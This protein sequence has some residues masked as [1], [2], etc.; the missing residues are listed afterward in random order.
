LKL[1][2][3]V[4]HIA[5]VRQA[6]RG[7]FPDP[8]RA[9]L[10]CQAAG[11]DAIVAHLREDRR[12]IQ[13][14][15]VRRL[16]SALRIKLNLEMAI[17]P[18]VLKTALAVCPHTATLVPERRKERTTE[19]GLDMVRDRSRLARATDSLRRRG[20]EVSF[21]VD[22][23]AAHIDAA[24][25]CGAHAVEIHTGTYAEA[26]TA[27]AAK[28]E[29]ERIRRAIQHAAKLSLKAHV[30]HG[31]DYTNTKMIAGIRGIDE[32][33]IGFSIISESFFTGL[34]QAVKRMHDLIRRH[35]PRLR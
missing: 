7:T 10:V 19:S 9:A 34:P 14:D 32:F 35:T 25:A 2:V 15:D 28:R 1:G 17:H 29:A 33:N 27:A 5:T 12:H 31:L 4:D 8:V 24:A 26:R 30:G 13:D 16:K 23:V 21:F 20:I 11:A 18:S 22:P 6:R 3:N